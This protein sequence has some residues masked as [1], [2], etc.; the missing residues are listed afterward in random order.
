M[1][2]SRRDRLTRIEGMV[3]AMRDAQTRLRRRL[4]RVLTDCTVAS[5][6]AY[7]DALSA[8]SVWGSSSLGRPAPVRP[9]A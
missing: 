5:I 4:G 2:A 3:D 1:R 7:T 8:A 9:L 6:S